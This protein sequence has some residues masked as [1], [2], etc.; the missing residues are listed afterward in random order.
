MKKELNLLATNAIIRNSSNS[1]KLK[2]NRN[3]FEEKL[4]KNDEECV[5]IK[6]K[7]ELKKV[8]IKYLN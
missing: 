7:E 6:L 4:L 3:M 8:M 1:P 2:I 5:N